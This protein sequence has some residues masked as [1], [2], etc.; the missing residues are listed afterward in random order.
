MRA[1][2]IGD[3]FRWTQR[4]ADAYGNDTILIGTNFTVTRIAPDHIGVEYYEAESGGDD[5]Y[6]VEW[7]QNSHRANGSLGMRVYVTELFDWVVD[8]STRDAVKDYSQGIYESPDPKTEDERYNDKVNSIF[9]RM[10]K[11]GHVTP[12]PQR[13]Y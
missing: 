1:I 4:A 7:N 3:Q 13:W 5:P 11:Q 10:F 2:S 9:S 12:V 6:T 8:Q